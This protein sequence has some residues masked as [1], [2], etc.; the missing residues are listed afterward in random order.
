[1]KEKKKILKVRPFNMANYSGGSGY[2]IFSIFFQIAL[3]PATLIV[4]LLSLVKLPKDDE[5]KLIESEARKRFRLV[6]TPLFVVSTIVFLIVAVYCCWGYGSILIYG[7]EILFAGAVPSVCIFF[8][9]KR[10]DEAVISEELTVVKA[11]L[12][13]VVAVVLVLVATL[14]ICGFVLEPIFNEIELKELDSSNG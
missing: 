13:S 14:F 10:L 3:L 4:W 7:F 9:M 5:G 12:I 8:I 2:L 6:A 11:I 1:M